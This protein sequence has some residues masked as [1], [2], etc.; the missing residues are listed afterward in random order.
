VITLFNGIPT[1]ETLKI[2]D[3]LPSYVRPK[4]WNDQ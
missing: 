1:D 2:F 4:L 3:T